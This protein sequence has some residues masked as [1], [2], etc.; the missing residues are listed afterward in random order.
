[1]LKDEI[2]Q[3]I[4]EFTLLIVSLEKYRLNINLAGDYNLNLLNLLPINTG[5]P[6]GSILGPL[7]FIIYS[8]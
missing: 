2:R 5:V 6:Q 7:L 4:N 3:F 1:M 8:S